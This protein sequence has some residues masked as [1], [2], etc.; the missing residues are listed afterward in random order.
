MDEQEVA[1]AGEASVLE[2]RARLVD[3]R[4]LLVESRSRSVSSVV[5]QLPVVAE[6]VAGEQLGDGLVL[7]P[8]QRRRLDHPAAQ[9]FAALRVSV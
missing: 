5:D 3:L 8:R 2:P 7:D 6:D 9:R 4:L 1:A